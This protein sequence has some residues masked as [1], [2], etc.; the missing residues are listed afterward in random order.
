MEFHVQHLQVQA[1]EVSQL[2]LLEM[3]PHPLHRIEVRG[4][5]RKDLE[6]DRPA[7]LGQEFSGLRPSVNR[8]PVPDHSSR[9]PAVWP[10]WKRK[11]ITC[12]PLSDSGR[13]IV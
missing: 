1:D 2:D 8:R 10:K 3:L 4:V 13:T 11:S 12:I 5:R 9:S 6:V 7:D